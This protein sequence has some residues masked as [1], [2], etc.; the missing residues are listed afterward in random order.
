[1]MT[2]THSHH[3]K[4]LLATAL[5]VLVLALIAAPSG[6]AGKKTKTETLRLFSKVQTFTFT[7]A[8]G[9]VS[10][11]PPAGPPHV[12]DMLEVDSLD[13]KGDH[14]RHSKRP[15]GS[16]YTHCTFVADSQEPDCFG[17]AALGGSLLRFH[18]LDIIGGTG[19]YEGVTGTMPQNK[20]V[21]G[22]SDVV[23]KLRLK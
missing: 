1:M 8:D 22:G 9:T 16:D 10:H 14:K 6:A 4:G 3:L 11:Q 13:F 19:R 23:M 5:G 2:V 18:G 20:E 7:T 21:H 17:Y 12:G 15:I